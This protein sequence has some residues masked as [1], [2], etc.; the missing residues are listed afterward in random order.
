MEEGRVARLRKTLIMDVA[1]QQNA[2]EA[3][4]VALEPALDHLNRCVLTR[5]IV[6]HDQL[7][8]SVGL[9]CDRLKAFLNEARVVE[10]A[11]SHGHERL[12]GAYLAGVLEERLCLSQSVHHAVLICLEACPLVRETSFRI[13]RAVSA[14]VWALS[15]SASTARRAPSIAVRPSSDF[16]SQSI[17]SGM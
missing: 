7:E 14:G 15:N 1:K 3:R 6:H 11:Y 12:V 16:R 4:G 2:L 10:K 5:I 17:R 9:R 8:R 13:G